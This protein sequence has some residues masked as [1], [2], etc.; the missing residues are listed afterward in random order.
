[1]TGTL[2]GVGVGPGDPELLTLKAVRIIEQA[3]V[4]ALPVSGSGD[5]AV[6]AIAGS[7]I[8]PQRVL[9]LDMPMT[10]DAQKLAD[11]HDQAFKAIQERLDAG[12]DVTFLTLGDPSVYSTF[13]PL[14]KRAKERGY[15]CQVIPGVPSFCAVAARL[16]WPLAER[17]EPLVILPAPYGKEA[18]RGN[19]VVMKVG[20]HLPR[21]SAEL[22]AQGRLSAAAL[23]ERCGME[24]EKIVLAIKGDEVSSTYFSTLLVKEARP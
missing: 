7:H 18:P 1:M 24:N 19:V 3:P 8:D 20:K 5:S 23:V 15:R 22:R 16:Q 11:S 9:E 21:L 2:Y 6:L 14:M 17:D 12:Q 13:T 10:M 4:I